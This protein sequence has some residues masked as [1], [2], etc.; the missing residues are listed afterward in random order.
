MTGNAIKPTEGY[1]RTV[2]DQNWQVRGT[3]DYDGDGRA[4]VLWRNSLSGENYLYPMDGTTIK[5]SEGYLRTVAD[6]DWRVVPA[7]AA[8]PGGP[9]A[10]GTLVINEVDYDQPGTDTLEFV[11]IYN[12]TGAAVSL[13][14]LALIF[15]NG[16]GGVEYGRVMLSPGVE[17]LPPGEHLVVGSSNV[18]VPPGTLQVFVQFAFSIQN[19]SPDG[20]AL[21]DLVN[22]TLI[23]ALSYGGQVT[24]AAITGVPGTYNLVEGTAASAVDSGGSPG[25]LVRLPNGTDTNNASSDWSF[26]S[27]PTPGYANAP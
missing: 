23:D 8:M 16:G 13:D 3:G 10:P 24:A 17:T 26:T 19:G 1:L 15:I 4:D 14:G 25:S 2:A 9:A 27:T 18:N 7:A 11:E 6:L 12:P 5:P 22:N 20:I 21:F